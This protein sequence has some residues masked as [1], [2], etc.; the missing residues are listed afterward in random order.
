[1]KNK[2][3]VSVLICSYNS[4]NYIIDTIKSVL[5]QTFKDFELLIL[6]N[7]STD[8]TVKN[9]LS[10]NDDRIKLFKSDKNYWP[11]WGLNYL[12][13]KSN[14]D[15]IT[16]LDHD[17]L[18]AK[19]KLQKQVTFLEENK[20]FIWCWTETIMYYESDKKYFKYYLK[21]KNNY[22]IHSSLMFRKW[23]Y[24]YDDRI[25]YFADAYFQKFILCNWKDLIYNIKE[26]L[27]FHLIKDNFNNLTYTW[28]KL[29][30]KNIKRLFQ[31][32]WISI[33]SFLALWYEI[34]RYL[35]IRNKIAKIFPKFFKLFDRLPYKIVWDWFKDFKWSKFESIFTLK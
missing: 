6:D 26:P 27:T 28:F 19:E 13:D 31:I 23:K 7:N 25:L 17:D 10:F 18:W 14:W 29:N 4:W 9:I 1:M 15:Y 5:N 2:Y 12:L 33:Y 21:E 24:R 11:Y 3:K 30:L 35:I 22:T 20:E 16:I 34:L 8:K 32:H